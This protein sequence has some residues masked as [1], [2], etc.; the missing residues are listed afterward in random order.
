MQPG[1][2]GSRALREVERFAPE[3]RRA[4]R[5]FGNAGTSRRVADAGS[6]CG[7]VGEGMLARDTGLSYGGGVKDARIG[8][9]GYIRGARHEVLGMTATAAALLGIAATGCIVDSPPPSALPQLPATAPLADMTPEENAALIEQVSRNAQALEDLGKTACY[10][11]SAKVEDVKA[12]G[13]AAVE[14][15]LVARWDAIAQRN[16]VLWA[17]DEGKDVT[18][19]LQQQLDAPVRG[20]ARRSKALKLSLGVG[21]PLPFTPARRSEYRFA[22]A[23]RTTFGDSIVAIAFEPKI[24]GRDTLYGTALVRRTTGEVL[25]VGATI[26]G[27]DRFAH[28]ISTTVTYGGTALRGSAQRFP[29]TASGEVIYA[30]G[31]VT[32]THDRLRV[33]I[34][35]VSFLTPSTEPKR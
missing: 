5:A 18:A 9:A 4:L 23:R 34:S 33:S 14:K 32:E 31:Y 19:E 11:L 3:P 17:N 25:S 30:R 21:F 22:P 28:L 26:I 7:S 27:W 35:D 10:T 13:R 1:P 8:R 2:E 15:R 6:A 16:N 24:A 29:S 20:K 12:D